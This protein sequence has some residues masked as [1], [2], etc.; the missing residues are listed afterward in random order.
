MEDLTKRK[1]MISKEKAAQDRYLGDS[2]NNWKLMELNEQ[3][4]AGEITFKPV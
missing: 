2:S 1:E 4:A 3:S